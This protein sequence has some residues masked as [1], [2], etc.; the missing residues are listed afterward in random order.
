LGQMTSDAYKETFN[1]PTTGDAFR[2][3]ID[4]IENAPR[5]ASPA[6]PN[7]RVRGEDTPSQARAASTFANDPSWSDEEQPA[8]AVALAPA[9]I[10]AVE[11]VATTEAEQLIWEYQPQ[12]AQGRA[13]GG[14]QRFKYRTQDEL[15]K[16]LTAAHTAATVEL[17]KRRTQAVIES[18]KEVATAYKEPEFLDPKQYPNA[19]AVNELARNAVANGTLS[20]LNLFKQNHPEFVLGGDNAAAMVKWVGKSGRNPSDS[21]TWELAWE[22]LKPYLTV[23]LTAAPA[24]EVPALAP[25]PVAAP[26]VTAAP[27]PA[28]TAQHVGIASGISSID[29]FSGDSPIEVAPAK[30]PG[31]KLI[32][33]GKSIVM[34]ARTWDRQS[35]EFQKRVLRNSANAVAINA[36][37]DQQAQEAA[38]RR[39]SQR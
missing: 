39:S 14:I 5:T 26:V 2:K 9:L 1:D 10:A 28:R 16:K 21:Q 13:V 33:D 31:V 23:E 19:E 32:L 7:G 38:A 22:A 12:D 27:A 20:A 30:V 24:A 37:Y 3:R 34:D 29:Q 4:I 36:M 11:P 35:S 8:S 18:V 25:A 15:I 17:R 6:R